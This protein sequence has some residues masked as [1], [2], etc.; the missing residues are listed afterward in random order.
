MNFSCTSALLAAS[1]ARDFRE[2]TDLAA[3]LGYNGLHLGCDPDGLVPAETFSFSSS[4]DMVRHAQERTIEIHCLAANQWTPGDPEDAAMGLKRLVCMAHALACPLVAVPLPALDAAVEFD[5]HYHRALDA[6]RNALDLC[7][8]LD[9]CLAVEP[10]VGTLAANAD[11]AIDLVDDV[12]MKNM[13]I[14]YN[15]R[16]LALHGGE[17]PDQAIPMLKD[18]LLMVRLEGQD[19]QAI[20]HGTFDTV[21]QML[22]D[23]GYRL[24]V[25]DCTRCPQDTAPAH[26]RHLLS[27]NIAHL[28]ALHQPGGSA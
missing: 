14:V 10:S 1:G 8:E 20:G 12:D 22:R 4:P 2:A 27:Q 21:V 13:G 23:V 7:E 28:R 19:M 11:E 26:L 9:I 17:P 24:Y 6:F 25:A 16:R 3:A 5:A 18:Y 15:P